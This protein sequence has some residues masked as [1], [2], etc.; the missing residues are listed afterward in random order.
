[1]AWDYSTFV[2]TGQLF[3]PLA[4][5]TDCMHVIRSCYFLMRPSVVVHCAIFFKNFSFAREQHCYYS[6]NEPDARP[7]SHLWDL[8]TTA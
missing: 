7:K 1:M 8:V 4:L 6:L 2:Q 3:I 5:Q